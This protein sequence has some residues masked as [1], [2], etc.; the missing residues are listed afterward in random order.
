[1]RIVLQHPRRCHGSRPIGQGCEFYRFA[2]SFRLHVR[3]VEQIV[4][5]LPAILRTAHDSEPS[6]GLRFVIDYLLDL[7]QNFLCH[8]AAAFKDTEVVFELADS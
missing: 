1:M 3:G 4:A 5:E 8:L 6:G 2:D 7:I